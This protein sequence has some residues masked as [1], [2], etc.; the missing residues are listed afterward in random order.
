MAK[1][2]VAKELCKGCTLCVGV[3]PKNIIKVDED[4]INAK[5]YHP[6][7]ITDESLC[8]ACASCALVCPDTVF[9][10]EK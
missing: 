3:C 4:Y 10:I 6:V 5:G 9:E 8:I 2:T 1:I 7:C